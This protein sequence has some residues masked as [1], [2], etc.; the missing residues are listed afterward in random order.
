[1]K[2]LKRIGIGLGVLLVLLL[3]AVIFMPTGMNV[4]VTQNLKAKPTTLFNIVNNLQNEK[5]WNPWQSQ[6]TSMV[7]SFGKITS[8]L[9]A[10][11]SWES[12]NMGSGNAEYIEVIK[13]KKIASKL[14]FGGMGSGIAEYRFDPEQESTNITWTLDSKTGRP[15]N[16]MNFLI[17]NDVKK[18]YKAGLEAL[19]KLAIE[20]EQK[21][22]YNGYQI[23][24][25]LLPEK[26][27]VTNRSEVTL[28]KIAQYY[29]Q[30]LGPL[31]QKIQQAELQMAGH[32]SGLF[33]S[34]DIQKG[35][36]D[37]AAGIPISEHVNIK[38]T[39]SQS[40]ENRRALVIDY[41]GDYANTESAHE[42]IDAYMADRNI[43]YEWPVIE[44]YVTDPSEEPNPEKWLTKI[45][46]YIKE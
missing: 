1:M 27:Y 34:Y 12:K 3:A 4:S 33:Y 41:Y 36:T 25:E 20:R 46:Y 16:V 9:G 23:K 39:S 42:A 31:F 18:S 29:A 28:D 32:P 14:N 40:F 26:T 35:T 45:Y 43:N 6:D 37:M 44:E 38:G 8:G 15:W 5:S 17:K 21:G 2:T 11:Y 19:E 22:I 30:N 24:E 7:T 13:N 10:K